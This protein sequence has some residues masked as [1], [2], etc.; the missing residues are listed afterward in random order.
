MTQKTGFETVD[1]NNPTSFVHAIPNIMGGQY[2]T[3][4]GIMAA[5]GAYWCWKEFKGPT[6]LKGS[7]FWAKAEHIKRAK[8]LVMEQRANPDPKELGYLL[9]NVPLYDVITS[10]F[11]F[12]APKSGKSFGSLNQAIFANLL[13]GNPQVIVDLQ[14]PVQTS[15]FI[16]IAQDLGYAPEDINLFVPGE[17]ESGSWNPCHSAVGSRA[18]EMAATFQ[19]NVSKKDAKSDD[20][21]TPACCQLIAADLSVARHLPAGMDNV[22]G[23]RAILNIDD[24]PARLREQ[25]EKLE[26]IDPW[27]FARFDQYLASSKSDKTASSIAGAAQNLFGQFCDEEIAPS[28]I[29]NTS[30]PMKM[31][32]KK[33]LIIGATPRLINM[34]S[35][36]LMALLGEVVRENSYEGRLTPLQIAIDELPMV[37][38]PKLIDEIN[39]IRKFGVFFNLAAQNLTQ[40][41]SKFGE[42]DT[43]SLLTGAGTKI[44]YNPRSNVSAQYLETALGSEQFRETQY[45]TG[46]SGGKGS[47]SSTKQ[48]KD[49]KLIS[50]HQILKLPQGVAIIQSRGVSGKG[51]EYIPWK[52]KV[53]PD[54]TYIKM[55]KWGAGQ[56]KFTRAQLE[57]YSPQQPPDGMLLTRARKAAE[58]LL[59]APQDA[60]APQAQ[61]PS[62]IAQRK[63]A[64]EFFTS[65][66]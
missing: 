13:M 26:K 11:T 54:K 46:S 18:L 62:A 39:Q 9:G 48:V 4:I 52:V 42:N 33:L 53:K 14:Y 43:E 16:A 12:G 8:Q 15:I 29:G 1:P 63:E 3:V 28:L 27:A 31:E 57:K 24:L 59:P 5:Y 44:W 35:P 20:F 58:D 41:R 47:T 50:V 36:L 66:S 65:I 40:M 7:A 2:G 37:T 60:T 61:T 17:K 23:C 55:M 25:R 30:F 64:A 51:E 34:V 32:G 10:I 19:A 38:Y 21:F 6:P 45:T 49:R 56:W 22:L